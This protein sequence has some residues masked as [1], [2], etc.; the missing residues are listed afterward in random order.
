MRVE[1]LTYVHMGFPVSA[2]GKGSACQF[3]RHVRC[4]FDPW[5]RK[6]PWMKAWQHMP[7]FLPGKFH[8]ERSL[9]GYSPWDH[10]ELV[11]TE[12][13]NT[14]VHMETQLYGTVSN[15]RGIGLTSSTC[16]CSG[17]QVQIRGKNIYLTVC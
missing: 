3:R 5:V 12:R 16:P 14:H 6:I 13:L 1:A 7:V 2:S 8:D 10:K 15:G 11:M 17:K 9:A 4:G